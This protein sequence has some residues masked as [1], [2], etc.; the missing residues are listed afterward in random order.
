[1]SASLYYVK[2]IELGIT[3]RWAVFFVEMY[4]VPLPEGDK[5]IITLIAFH[6]PNIITSSHEVIPNEPVSKVG[7]LVNTR[8]SKFSPALH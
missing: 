2:E 3:S 4:F 5:S 6:R 1:L 8:G 7:W